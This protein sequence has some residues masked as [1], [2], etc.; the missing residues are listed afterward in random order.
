MAYKSNYLDFVI[1]QLRVVKV[2][3]FLY[4]TVTQR[5]ENCT[6]RFILGAEIRLPHPYQG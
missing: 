4:S 2:L 3:E 6:I 5:D 1:V